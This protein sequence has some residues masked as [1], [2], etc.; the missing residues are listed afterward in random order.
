[1]PFA[2][3]I[4]T[5]FLFHLGYLLPFSLESCDASGSAISLPVDSPGVMG[6]S[7]AVLK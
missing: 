3:F 1:M 2:L 7:R 6:L 4:L 5:Q